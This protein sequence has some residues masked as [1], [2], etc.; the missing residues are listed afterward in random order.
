MIYSLKYSDFGLMQLC[1]YSGFKLTI[2]ASSLEGQHCQGVNLSESSGVPR[3][4]SCELWAV[5]ESFKLSS[6]VFRFPPVA[7]AIFLPLLIFLVADSWPLNHQDNRPVVWSADQSAWNALHRVP[8]VARGSLTI[9]PRP[10]FYLQ[11]LERLCVTG[12]V[13]LRINT[14]FS[15]VSSYIQAEWRQ[16]EE[17]VTNTVMKKKEKKKKKTTFPPHSSFPCLATCMLHTAGGCAIGAIN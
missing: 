13:Q 16:D 8:A 11:W 14:A 10:T 5:G 15:A 17:K 4:W 3:F 2:S 9:S 12:H 1:R 6:L 7:W